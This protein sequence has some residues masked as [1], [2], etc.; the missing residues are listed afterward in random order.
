MKTRDRRKKVNK[1]LKHNC[2]GNGNGFSF[3]YFTKTSF[4][5]PVTTYCNK[6]LVENLI[7]FQLQQYFNGQ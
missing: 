5:L 4:L 7:C 3:T 1:L 2:G 6:K